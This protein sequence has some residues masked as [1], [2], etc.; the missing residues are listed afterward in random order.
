MTMSFALRAHSLHGPV[1]ITPVLS[2]PANV[3]VNAGADATECGVAMTTITY[4]ATDPSGNSVS[5]TQLVTVVDKTPPA[6]STGTLD[7]S[8]G[9][10]T[11]TA[12]IESLGTTAADNCGGTTLTG[13][14]SVGAPLAD[15]FSIGSTT[16]AW[17]TTDAACN[18]GTF[19]DNAGDLHTARWVCDEFPGMVNESAKTVTG[20]VSFTAAGV[21]CVRLEVTDQCG[22]TASTTSIAGLQA[23]V[24]VYDPSAGFVTG[25]G[26]IDSPTG[27]YPAVPALT[28]NFG[29]A[30][31]KG[32][33]TP[34]GTSGVYYAALETARFGG[35]VRMV[36]IK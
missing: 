21:H 1:R 25:G 15:P 27:A 10:M 32:P 28:G 8:T 16:I 4:T 9:D 11:C 35:P 17:T 19:T 2:A 26:W 18:S 22:N 29:F 33:S 5:E 12:T 34:A 6:I 31:R 24:V 13:L 30:S 14:R 20:T 7:V 36:L 3:T 23:M